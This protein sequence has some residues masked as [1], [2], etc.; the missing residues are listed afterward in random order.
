MTR[1]AAFNDLVKELEQEKGPRFLFYFFEES[2]D[3]IKKL[4]ERE[5]LPV[6]ET[7]TKTNEIFLL[8]ARRPSLSTLPLTKI[9][10]IYCTDHFPLRS[11]FENFTSAVSEVN[12]SLTINVYG[13][14]NEPVFNVFGGDRI[15]DLMIKMGMKENE[16]IEHSMVSKAIENAQEKIE[17]KIITESTA[18]NA[19]E[20][21]KRNLP[22]NL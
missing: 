6:H 12:P 18:H 14:L 9:S 5:N 17:K 22:E 10:K 4:L 21:F 13:G 11:V 19:T 7:V 2:R 15:K 1:E 8:N 20:W 16:M 3:V